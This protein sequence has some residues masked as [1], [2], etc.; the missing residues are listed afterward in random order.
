M[1]TL[2]KKIRACTICAEHLPLG[3]KPILN[4]DKHS[5]VLI[6]GQAPGVKAHNSGTPWDD[7]SGERLRD[8]LGVTP[9]EFY[10]PKL[11]AIVPM[12]FCYPGKGKSGDLPPRP[13]CSATWMPP[14]LDYLQEIKTTIVIGAYAHKYLLNSDKNVT[15]NIKNWKKFAPEFFPL[16]HPSPRNNIW[17]AQNPWFLRELVPQL[18]R[19]VGR[20]LK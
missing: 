1:N 4:F 7:A 16:P 6:V 8:W 10:N 13:E 17:L 5:K 20:A 11:F 3:P 14:I 9:A 18:K 19:H 15:E 12:G 2:L